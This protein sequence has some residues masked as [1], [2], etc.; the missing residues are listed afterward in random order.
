[1][2]SNIYDGVFLRKSLSLK[3]VLLP[4][5]TLLHQ[6]IHFLQTDIGLFIKYVRKTFFLK[7]NISYTLICTTTCVYQ[8]VKNVT[9]EKFCVGTK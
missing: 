9:I 3:D 8:G 1:M 7:I 2:H 6:S 5:D 4:A